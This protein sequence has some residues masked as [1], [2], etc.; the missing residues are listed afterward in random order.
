VFDPRGEVARRGAR[1][2]A[3][4]DL[5]EVVDD[6]ELDGARGVE[7]FD[8]WG[9]R[10]GHEH[11]VEGV[12]AD[13]LRFRHAAQGPAAAWHAVEDLQLEERFEERRVALHA[14]SLCP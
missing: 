12:L 5:G 11:H 4:A 8:A 1:E 10:P 9:E 2:V 6:G 13:A 3:E 14:R 7:A